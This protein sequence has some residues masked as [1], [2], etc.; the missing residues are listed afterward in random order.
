MKKLGRVYPVSR[1]FTFILKGLDSKNAKTR[2]ECLEEMASLIQRHGSSVLSSKFI[3]VIASQVADRDNSCRNAALNAVTQI[4]ELM[5]EDCQKYLS[6]LSEKEKDMISERLR[7]LPG[8][9]SNN[10]LK[11]G[12]ANS[13]PQSS[14]VRNSSPL[15]EKLDGMSNI[16]KEFS[17]D[18]D[19]VGLGAPSKSLQ[20]ARTSESTINSQTEFST[21]E[22]F[23]KRDADADAEF[24]SLVSRL[25]SLDGDQA[26]EAAKSIEKMLSANYSLLKNIDVVGI[27]NPLVDATFSQ[28]VS[29]PTYSPRFAKHLIS[30]LLQI[31]G[32]K[33]SAI[34]V[35]YLSL[36]AC[37]KNIILRLVDSNLQQSDSTK[38]LPRALNMLMVRIID[39]C[40]PNATFRAL[41]LILKDGSVSDE[42]WRNAR[43]IQK[44]YTELAMKCLWKI[45]KV[46]PSFLTAGSLHVDLLLLEINGFLVAAPPQF[47]KQKTSNEKDSPLDMPLRTVK[48]ILHELVNHLGDGINAFLTV[49]PEQNHTT[50]YIRQMLQSVKKKSGVPVTTPAIIPSARSDIDFASQL[51]EIFSQIADKQDTKLGLQRLFELKSKFPSISP[52][53]EER[54]AKTG[55]YFQGYIRRGLQS[56]EERKSAPAV[57]RD[58]HINPKDISLV[59]KGIVLV[60]CYITIKGIPPIMIKP[61]KNCKSYFTQTRLPKPLW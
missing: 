48:T 56:L 21:D 35:P 60:I 53:V 10:V 41:L 61:F 40:E 13:R 23:Y 29:N 59:V 57:V 16:P 12:S 11:T 34:F 17:L 50:A 43:D 2:A 19:K 25:D 4:Y 33:E 39:N 46:I 20:P 24:A 52:L 15:K 14:P 22:I 58:H 44:K 45:T 55:S 49:F 8:R 18:L 51:D 6:K 9:T 7:R 26:A 30:S 28:I 42:N 47:W 27:V 31:F 5:G 38:T 1:L 36:E 54:L 32:T 3:P 37:I